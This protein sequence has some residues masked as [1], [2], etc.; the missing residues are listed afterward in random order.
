MDTWSF[1][2]DGVEVFRQHDADLDNRVDNYRWLGSA[3]MKWGVDANE[4]GIIDSWRMI[5]ADE[6]AQEAFEALAEQNFSR[7]KALFITAEEVQSLGLPSNQAAAIAKAQQTAAQKFQQTLTK[8]PVLAK[9]TFVRAEGVPGCWPADVTGASQD[10]IKF[11]SRAILFETAAKKHEWLQT[12]D[13]VQVGAVWRLLDV[14]G[15]ADETGPDTNPELQKLLT[16]LAELDKQM[17][18]HGGATPN[19]GVASYNERRAG[20]IERIVPHIKDAGDRETWYKQIFDSLSAGAIAGSDKAK[21]R[22]SAYRGQLTAKMPGSN[23][24]GYVVFRELWTE[25][26]PK[27]ARPDAKLQEEWHEA[28]GKFVKEY[29]KAEDT[30]EAVNTLAMGTEFSGKDEESARWYRLLHTSFPEHPLAEHAKGAERRLKLVGNPL[31][32]AGP[33]LQNNT[34][35]NIGQLKGK[36]AIVYYWTSQCQSC[37]ADFARFKQ[38]LP[39]FS[40]DVELVCVNLDTSIEDAI[41][42]LQTHPVQATH[43]VQRGKESGLKGPL[44]MHYGINILPTVFLVGRDGRVINH[45]LNVAD[46]DEALKKAVGQ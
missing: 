41:R 43:V 9:A 26:Q 38:H 4:D 22:L 46:M 36:V 40:K 18:A 24:A 39:A 15:A 16:E 7:L 19:E 28:L 13:I 8:M 45:R 23:L 2:K 42:Y 14:P 29:P 10:I 34:E 21:A 27:L 44:A 37:P 20:I 30:P 12:G 11:A 32:L 6:V 35:F 5:S 31:E 1:F 33:T 25:Y 17:P 3:G